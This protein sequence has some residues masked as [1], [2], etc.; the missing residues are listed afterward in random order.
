MLERISCWV[1]C[2]NAAR[3]KEGSSKNALRQRRKA[4]E[5]DVGQKEGF[6]REGYMS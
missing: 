2:E 5:I 4:R 1:S 3:Q 6:G